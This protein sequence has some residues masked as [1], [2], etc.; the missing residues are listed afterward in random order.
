[1][2]LH[3]NKDV[4]L[5]LVQVTAQNANLPE[6]YVEKD[7]WVTNALRNLA[8]S[9]LS[10]TVVFKGGTSLSKA[11]KL[12][13]RFSE[14]IDL[15]V[16][17]LSQSNSQKRNLI[18]E[19][20][21]V[22][23]KG[24]TQIEDDPRMSKAS[25]FRKTVWHYPRVFNG[26][27]FG[28]ASSNLLIEVAAFVE[29]Q[30]NIVMTLD[31][32]IAEE[33]AN[34]GKNDLIHLYNLESFGINVLAV[35]RTLTE[36]ILFLAKNSYEQDPISKLSVGIR[37]LY[38]INKILKQDKFRDFVLAQGFPSLVNECLVQEANCFKEKEWH[39]LPLGHAPIF[40]NIDEWAP[41]LEAAYTGEFENM[42]YGGLPGF[43][44]VVDSIKFIRNYL[45]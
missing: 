33:L 16:I 2:N 41:L 18:K 25:R 36:K 14:D 9:K 27:N 42:V 45:N 40:E 1:M 11:H 35:E 24:L 19:I 39:D 20:E 6:I 21:C 13:E 43:S 30:P 22:A 23:A 12:I 10:Q 8:S 3:E 28:Q 15:A 32:M 26:Q 7:Y 4:F 44:E 37:H 38:D 5:E 34:L 29:P 31:S 17:D